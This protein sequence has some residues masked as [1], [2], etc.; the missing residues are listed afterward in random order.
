MAASA[1]KVADT[2][3]DK[4]PPT[5][6]PDKRGF[7]YVRSMV[8]GLE[9]PPTKGMM[10]VTTYLK[11]VLCRGKSFK[12]RFP[13]KFWSTT[14]LGDKTGPKP[15]AERGK[16]IG[17]YTDH[18][19]RRVVAGELKLNRSNFKHR[20]CIKLFEALDKHSLRCV[21][22]QVRVCIPELGI[23]TELDG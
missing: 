14:G 18:L 20:R 23:K 22:T 10:G 7:A 3:D 9:V 13:P 21:A 5:H 11:Q 4:I 8:L 6:T 2:D 16:T 12:P 17:R 15:S 19:F 1:N